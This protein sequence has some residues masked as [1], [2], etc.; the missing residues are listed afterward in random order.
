MKAKA[1]T[2]QFESAPP[3]TYE[4]RLI[5]IVDLGTQTEEY[6]GEKQSP[7]PK[8]YL[9]WEL[10]GDHAKM[11]DGRPFVQG[12]RYNFFMSSGCK[13]RKDIEAGLNIRFSSQEEA[14]DFPFESLLG[15]PFTLALVLNSN[16]NIKIASVSGVSQTIIS[17]LPEQ[18]NENFFFDIDDFKQEKF[19]SLN[20][21]W[22]EMIKESPEYQALG[23]QTESI[24]ED[25][26]A[27]LKPPVES[28]ENDDMEDEIP[29]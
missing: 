21:Y 4:A 16:N 12:K 9:Q 5:K 10:L 7:M 19:E 22:Q 18:V 15:K 2:S 14:D 29:F 26:T 25:V 1:S 11:E 17:Q 24:V 27:D 6:N 13:L 28:F 23:Q 20:N 8:V 3:G